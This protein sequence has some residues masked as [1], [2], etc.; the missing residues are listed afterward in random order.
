MV[1][2]LEWWVPSVAEIPDWFLAIVCQQ[3]AV[4]QGTGRWGEY[5]AQLLWQRGIRDPS[6]LAGFLNPKD[7]Q[8]SS[9]FALGEEM[10]RTVNRLAIA[11]QQG[12]R[13]VIWGDCDVD[14]ITATAVL[15]EGL[16]QFFPAD[17]LTYFIPN[18]FTEDQGLSI[19]GIDALVDC[20]LIV[21]GG[22][23]STNA[24][25]IEYAR[26]LGIDIIVIDPHTVDRPPAIALI[27]SHGLPTHHPFAQLSGVALAYKVVEA[28]Y[29]TL[30]ET[31]QRPLEDLLDLVAIGLIAD[32]VELKGDCRYLAQIGIA[33][34]QQTQ[35]L[36]LVRL[37]ELCKRSGDRP[38][39]ISW[40]LSARINAISHIQGD[41]RFC[42]ELLTSLD[43]SRCQ[44]LAEETELANIRC[45]SLQKDMAQ[46][47]KARIA[48]LDLSTT[49]AI[50]LSDPQWT[51]E[52]LGL[53]AAQ[54][55]QE[56]Q[57]P[58]ILLGIEPFANTA[59]EAKGAARSPESINLY[60][61]LKEQGHLLGSFGGHP[62]AMDIRLPTENID[63][64]TAAINRQLRQQQPLTILTERRA[65]LTV[66]VAELGQGLFRELKL[67]EPYGIGNPVPRLLIQNCWFEKVW[68]RNVEDWRGRKVR[69]IKTE[70]ELWDEGTQLGFPGVWWEHYR[71]EILPGRC[72]AIAELDFNTAK[73][74]YE[75]RL[76]TLRPTRTLAPSIQ[77]DWLLDY[78]GLPQPPTTGVLQLDQCPSHWDE[79]QTLFREAVQTQQKLAIAYPPPPLNLPSQTWQTLVGIAKYLSRTGKA[80]TYQQFIQK[81]ELSDRALRLGFQTLE[82]L[83]FAV[84]LQ[85]DQL[86]VT[87]QAVERV[88]RQAEI[89]QAIANFL[90]ILQEE[91]FHQ[92]YFYK[93][94]MTTIQ[95]IAYQTVRGLIE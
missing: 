24:L 38:T 81:L 43:P 65:D 73:K 66:T 88:E 41:A 85:G 21:T 4:G 20:T 93:V 18:R 50:V 95:A 28:M 61:L 2:S 37:L 22:T 9:S 45:R 33:K 76:I 71:D 15:W 69:Y 26:G 5:A 91:R 40:G 19:A 82:I 79:L 29:E 57:R 30:P 60:S 55:V 67:L 72:D 64:L 8:P 32:W 94:P 54:M 59:S 90:E 52:V 27:N 48:Q 7:Y 78:R 62:L 47:V 53:V 56:Y 14:G 23:G 58:V 70:F 10:Q 6:Q 36:G 75:L 3:K 86:Q 31:P 68:H 44:H 35:R 51:I 80:A 89:D 11:R 16:G 87:Y 17:F 74:R 13:V 46:Q 63:L 49:P 39:D 83:G 77:L 25:E 1:D 12:E 92:H 42:V 84:N 34:L